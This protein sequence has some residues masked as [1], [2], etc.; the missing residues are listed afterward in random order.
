MKKEKEDTENKYMDF[1]SGDPDGLLKNMEMP[2]SSQD[3]SEKE[4]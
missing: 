1:M 4:V 2:N 3:N